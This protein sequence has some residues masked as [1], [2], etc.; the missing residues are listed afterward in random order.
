MA[1][2]VNGPISSG[3]RVPGRPGHQGVDFAVPVGTGVVSAGSGTV[4]R[5]SDHPTYGNVVIIDHGVN[6]AGNHIYSL[7]SHLSQIDVA[8]GA[9]A[10]GQAIGLSGGAVGAP[11]AGMPAHG[12]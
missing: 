7:Y 6:A 3:Y 4:V 11:G 1:L 8:P 5:A 12:W 2:P 9:I 10:A